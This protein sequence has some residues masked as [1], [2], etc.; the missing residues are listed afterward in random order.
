MCINLNTY[1]WTRIAVSR[2][3]KEDK[4]KTNGRQKESSI[5]PWSSGQ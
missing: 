4:R 5:I 1:Y 2:L 3:G